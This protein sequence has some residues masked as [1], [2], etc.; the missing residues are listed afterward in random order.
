MDLLL[1][2]PL[3]HLNDGTLRGVTAVSMVLPAHRFTVLSLICSTTACCSPVACR[4]CYFWY[5]QP[6]LAV[7]LWRAGHAVA[8]MLNHRRRR[9]QGGMRGGGGALHARLWLGFPGDRPHHCPAPGAWAGMT[10]LVFRQD[11]WARHAPELRRSLLSLLCSA[12]RSML[13]LMGAVGAGHWWKHVLTFGA[14]RAHSSVQRV[15][16]VHLCLRSACSTHACHQHASAKESGCEIQPCALAT[17]VTQHITHITRLTS[18]TCTH[19]HT[20]AWFFQMLPAY[21]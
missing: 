1:K 21:S 16:R 12:S 4:A 18:H 8:D 13:G 3:C 10:Y 2:V 9:A 11:N 17:C 20:H 19:A 5:T 6:Q 7:L 14:P 15:Y